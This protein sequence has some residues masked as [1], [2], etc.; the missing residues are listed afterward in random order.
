M[1]AFKESETKCW[2]EEKTGGEGQR[3]REMKK[4]REREREEESRMMKGIRDP[5]AEKG[6]E[7]KRMEKI[8]TMIRKTQTTLTNHQSV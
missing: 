8:A 4:R 1:G 7:V 3:A 6:M 5:V 2:D